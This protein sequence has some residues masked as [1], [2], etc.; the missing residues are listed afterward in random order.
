[1]ERLCAN[2]AAGAVWAAAPLRIVLVDPYPPGPGRIWRQAQSE[3]MWL[4]TATAD[5]TIFPDAS[6]QCEGP[7]ATG[8]SF[9]DWAGTEAGDWLAGTP[10]VDEAARVHPGSFPTRHFYSAYLSWTLERVIATAPDHVTIEWRAARAV[11]VVDGSAGRQVVHL[12][13]GG[14]V[15]ADVVVLAQGHQDVAPAPEEADLVDFAERHGL[16][17]LP[18]A[19]TADADLSR[20]APGMP[21]LV[22]GVG[23]A[24]VDCMALLFEGRGGR[25]E[26][27]G[28]GTLVYRP[29]GAEPRLLIGS[30]RGVPYHSKTVYPLAGG[31]PPLPRFFSP[32]VLT[33]LYERVGPLDM[34][35]DLWPLLV[36][37]LA[38]G[39]YH[40]LWHGHPER[41]VGSWDDFVRVIE[42]CGAS[43]DVP[44]VVAAVP[45][46]A[47]RLDLARL[48]APLA[49]VPLEGADALQEWMRRHLLAD[50]ARRTDPAQSSD[51]GLITALLTSFG[52][53]AL[54]AGAGQLSAR[55][56]ALG[57]DGR[58]FGFFSYVASGPPPARLEQLIAL[59]RAGLVEFLGPDL[60]VSADPVS[61]RFRAERSY[62]GPI[63][64]SA[65][66]DARLPAPSVERSQDPL[67]VALEAR[68]ET[69]ED[70]HH[71]AGDGFTYRT[72]R[73]RTD[74]SHRVVRSDGSAHPARFAVGPWTSGGRATSGIARPHINAAFFHQNDAL[75]QTALT[76]LAETLRAE[77]RGPG[78]AHLH[79][80]ERVGHRLGLGG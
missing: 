54:A 17:Y 13:D 55:T 41:T 34:T 57:V 37:D 58:F 28:E 20:F 56:L 77:T 72:G 42:D 53:L 51:L 63:E 40:E 79:D 67:L 48:E 12:D 19:Y 31:R 4:N 27:D 64:A 69:A 33:D 44:A 7:V 62:G 45:D 74:P 2:A 1:V 66:L 60:K 22:R 80:P 75:A 9:L 14:R 39:H 36:K 25:Y 24:F 11:D 5:N 38:I 21:V 23:L 18:R 3:L 26:R 35:R 50:L 10:L 32:A 59:S 16:A 49:D 43:L 46:P 78:S 68:G 8:P 76:L 47:D 61:G 15:E 70:V 65:L 6:V 71:D 30:R 52:V 73:L 29:S